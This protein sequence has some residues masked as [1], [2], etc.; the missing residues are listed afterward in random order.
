M[1]RSSGGGGDG[2]RVER[3]SFV[4]LLG[5]VKMQEIAYR[6]FSFNGLKP[7]FLPFSC[8]ITTRGLSYKA[9]IPMKK[10]HLDRPR[11]RNFR[12]M[13]GLRTLVTSI[14][15]LNPIEENYSDVEKPSPRFRMQV[16][17]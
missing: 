3:L 9:A 6:A 11:R 15:V 1:H 13:P 14:V 4:S 2:N 17:S 12:P 10:Q 5:A 8:F 16:V 7:Q